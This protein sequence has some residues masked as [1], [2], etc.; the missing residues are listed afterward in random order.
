[1]L[2]PSTTQTTSPTES[3]NMAIQTLHNTAQTREAVI[4]VFLGNTTPIGWVLVRQTAGYV[5]NPAGSPNQFG[6]V[7]NVPSVLEAIGGNSLLVMGNAGIA[8]TQGITQSTANGQNSDDYAASQIL[9]G[10]TFV[11]GPVVTG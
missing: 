8:I 1:M 6:L 7:Q 4:R 9:D 2:E 3:K 5:F 10:A 11:R